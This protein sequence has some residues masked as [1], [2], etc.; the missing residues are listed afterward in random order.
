MYVR[1]YQCSFKRASYNI[2]Y[3][4][5]C[6]YHLIHFTHSVRFSN[7]T[8]NKLKGTPYTLAL[9]SLSSLRAPEMRGV[10]PGVCPRARVVGRRHRSHT[11][12]RLHTHDRARISLASHTSHR[13]GDTYKSVPPG[14]S[15]ATGRWW[16]TVVVW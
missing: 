12:P 3:S 9:V 8:V 14:R 7:D 1:L 11:R 2:L 4:R 10:R 13:R 15:P 16:A 5:D 6:R